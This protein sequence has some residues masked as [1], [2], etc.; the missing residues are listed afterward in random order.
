MKLSRLLSIIIILLNQKTVT[1]AQLDATDWI[2]IDFSPWGSHPNVKNK[3]TDLKNAILQN[4]VIEISYINAQNVKSVRTVE[5]LRLDFKHSAWYLWA[6]YIHDNGDGTFNLEINFPEDEWVYGYILSF[7][8]NVK[9]I[10]PEH[11]KEIIRER[12]KKI[13]ELYSEP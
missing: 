9:V 11:V 4:R 1:A 8:T 12:S 5:P 3:F 6:W 7:G 13:A 2:N 10:E